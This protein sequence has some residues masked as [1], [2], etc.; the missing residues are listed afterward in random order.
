M[1]PWIGARLIVSVA[2]LTTLGWTADGWGQAKIPR[3][4]ILSAPLLTGAAHEA[5]LQWYEPLRRALAEHGWVEGKSVS[6]EYRSAPG[7]PPRYD[8]AAAELLRLKVD[9]IY[10]E[11]APAT[12]AAYAATRTVPIVA[13][14]Y[15]NDPVTAGYAETYARPS[16]NLTGLFL[17]APSFAGKWL[18]LL[19]SIVPGLS[20]VAVIWDPSPGGTIHLDAVRGAARTFR[21]QLQV[22]EVHELRDIEKAFAAL[23]PRSQALIILPSPMTWGQSARLAELATQHRLPATSMALPFAEAG[24]VLSYGPDPESALERCGILVGRILS[25]AKPADLAVERPSKFV[26]AVN[27]K[28]AKALQLRIPDSIVLNADKVIK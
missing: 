12:R 9:V 25:G 14:D 13:L 27:L 6:F 20:R 8:E 5:I 26:L 4:G 15:T 21:V 19:K 18:E 22:L 16:R 24:G 3:V 17:D 2:L 1:K 10:A 23:R 11:S 7:N 28:T